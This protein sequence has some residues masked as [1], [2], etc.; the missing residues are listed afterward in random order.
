MA[1]HKPINELVNDLELPEWPT[2]PD[3]SFGAAVEAAE[4][5]FRE[6]AATMIVELKPAIET[7]LA[8]WITFKRDMLEARLTA[9]LPDPLPRWIATLCPERWLPDPVWEDEDVD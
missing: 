1:Q 9:Y 4:I 6:L 5:A 3:G 2:W 7:I 8:A